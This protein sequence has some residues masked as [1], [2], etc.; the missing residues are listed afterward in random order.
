MTDLQDF[1]AGVDHD[2][3]PEDQVRLQ[4]SRWLRNAGA[5]VY[6]DK[7]HA[8]GWNTF[9][10][11][12]AARPDLLIVGAERNYAVEVKPGDDSSKVFDAL[13]QIVD[14]WKSV[15]DG[16]TDYRVNGKPVDVDAF[17]LATKHSPHGRLLSAH[18]QSEVMRTNYS[19]GRQAAMNA[20]QLPEREFNATERLVRAV[21]RFSKNQR[22]EATTGIGALLSSYLDGGDAGVED[23]DPAVLF[24]SHDGMQMNSGTERWQWWE[25]VPFYNK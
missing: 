12:S 10:P 20:G 19:E 1:D 3:G 13:P 18:G 16:D 25:Y 15:V 6:W 23:S 2:P 17:V 24:K 8:Y 14:Y 4:L 22:P 11:G 5:D 7:D 21:W 9:D